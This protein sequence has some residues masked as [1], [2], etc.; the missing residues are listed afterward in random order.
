MKMTPMQ[1]RVFNALQDEFDVPFA[2]AHRAKIT[3][4]SPT[5]TAAKICRQL[6]KMG[7]AE[8]CGSRMYPTWRRVKHEG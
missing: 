7:L 1:Q 4:I 6:T 3:T 8:E 2:I 5:E